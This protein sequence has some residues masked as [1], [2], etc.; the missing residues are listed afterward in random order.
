VGL[1]T[2]LKASKNSNNSITTTL[3]H[4]YHHLRS[5]LYSLLH[6]LHPFP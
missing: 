3:I 1:A 5:L 4:L 6:S 2:P